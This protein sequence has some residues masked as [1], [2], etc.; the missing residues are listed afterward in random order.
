MNRSRYLIGVLVLIAVFSAPHM[1]RAAE[2]IT[3]E[4]LVKKVEAL[5]GGYSGLRMRVSAIETQIAPT[6]T[7][8]RRETLKD[9]LTATS[10]A[11]RVT[12]TTRAQATR[13]S[14][15]KAT[16]TAQALARRQTSRANATATA[17]AN[18]V[19]RAVAVEMWNKST[20]PVTEVIS[21]SLLEIAR[22]F[23]IPGYVASGDVFYLKTLLWQI[24]LAYK[25]ALAIVPPSSLSQVH[26]VFLRAMGYCNSGAGYTLSFL[27]DSDAS[28]LEKAILAF[29]ECGYSMERATQMLE[30]IQR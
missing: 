26:E 7:I 3:F 18:S 6:P 27:E 15:A 21:T 20:R 28:D 4:D 17:R 14:K 24:Q 16:A 25:D 29:D 5:T 2:G 8:D 30:A 13:R 23:E 9:R 1:I 11:A 19:P 22:L 12:V 10:Q